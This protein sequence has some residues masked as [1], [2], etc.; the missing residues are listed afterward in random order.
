[1]RMIHGG[2]RHPT[3]GGPRIPPALGAGLAERAQAVLAVAHIAGRR[4]ALYMNLTHLAGTQAQRAVI[5]LA[6]HCVFPVCRNEDIF[7]SLGHWHESWTRDSPLGYPARR[8]KI[9]VCLLLPLLFRVPYYSDKDWDKDWLLG[10]RDI[11]NATNERTV[12]AGVMPLAG[13]GNQMPLMF[14]DEQED[15][16]MYA[17]LVANL[18]SLALD[19]FARHKVG[20]THLNFFIAKQIAVLPP[21]AYTETDLALIVPRALELTYTAW[22]LQALAQNLGYDGA[23]F[24]FSGSG[25]SCPPTT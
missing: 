18:S 25:P 7:R 9:V 22:D 13:M 19:F 2:H 11:T 12:I 21:D 15:K 17:A 23:P 16:R 20:G 6:R 14:P 1:M 5:A 3:H 24:A 10:F 8:F 4:A